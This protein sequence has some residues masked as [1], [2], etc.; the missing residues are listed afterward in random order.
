MSILR[1]LVLIVTDGV[2]ITGVA[3]TASEPESGAFRGI[4]EF[5]ISIGVLS[6]LNVSS[7]VSVGSL[8]TTAETAVLMAPVVVCPLADQIVAAAY[9][10]VP[11]GA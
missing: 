6:C 9:R 7:D 10:L 5:E 4:H 11:S 3:Q 8:S 1:P 2:P